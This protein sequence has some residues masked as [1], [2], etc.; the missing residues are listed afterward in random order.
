MIRFRQNVLST[1]NRF[2]LIILFVITALLLS[3]ACTLSPEPPPPPP[4]PPNQSPVIDS[5]TAEKEVTTSSESQMVCKADDP[6]GDT[7]TYQWSA[8]GGTIKGAGSSVA[9]V[10]PDTAGNYNIKVTVAD[11]KGGTASQS[12][13]IAAISK[14]NQP[15]V[16]SGLTIDGSPP[17]EENRVKQWITKTIHCDAQD[18]DGDQLTYLWRATGGKVTGTGDTVGWTSPGVNGVYT[19]TVVVTDSRDGKAEASI[20]FKV[21][22]CGGG[23]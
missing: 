14:P 7:L 23:F 16:I 20:V 22:C 8:D 18:P 3:S 17:G 19:I 21:I 4:P 10:A 2:G 1:H 15:P 11:G 9:W 13:T 5:L 12:I 6:D